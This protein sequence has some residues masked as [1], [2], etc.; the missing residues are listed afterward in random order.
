MTM[1]RGVNGGWSK[2]PANPVLGGDYGTC[3]D[4]AMLIDNGVL[5]MY[6][7]WR[8]NKSIALTESIDGVHWSEPVF[9]IK[10]RETAEGWEDDLNRPTVVKV[11]NIYH[12]WY[13]GQ[14]SPGQ[15]DGTSHIFYATSEDGIVF[16]RTS[17]QPVL[18]AE[19]PW[20]KQ[21]VMC[22]SA[23]WD[24]E[25]QCFYMWYSGGEQYEPNAIGFARSVD[26]LHWNK[27]ENNPIFQAD[28]TQPWEQHKVAGC[29][30]FRYN[31]LYYM[32]YIGYFNEHYAQIGIARSTNGITDW[33][34][35][36]YNPIVAPDKDSWD[37]EA[38]YKPFVLKHNGQWMLW[39]NGRK[40]A[41]EQIGLAVNPQKNFDF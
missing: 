37:A 20:E 39:Y 6:F 33:E 24:N 3:F 21:A 2:H 16:H 7:S 26:G 11:R 40:G 4:I 1:K 8:D 25:A 38:C 41:K 30:V 35:S 19:L 12:M 31:G 36:M 34:R 5:K 32:F 28:S 9:C 23:I 10:P 13:T 22:P 14:F 15:Q 18:T 17:D 27:Y 29:Q